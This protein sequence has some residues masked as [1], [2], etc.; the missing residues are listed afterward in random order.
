MQSGPRMFCNSLQGKS[1][2][3]KVNG[4][5][6]LTRPHRL[7]NQHTGAANIKIQ[8]AQNLRNGAMLTPISPALR[9]FSTAPAGDRNMMVAMT[10][11]AP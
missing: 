3:D 11:P 6:H 1:C 8:L 4:T 7:H 9:A 5:A 2:V 10:P